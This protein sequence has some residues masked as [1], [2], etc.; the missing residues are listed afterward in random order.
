MRELSQKWPDI[1]NLDLAPAAGQHGLRDPSLP[2]ASVDKYRFRALPGLPE[3]AGLVR[4]V[5]LAKIPDEPVLAHARMP[6][7]QF[8]G[9]EKESPVPI[10]DPLVKTPFPEEPAGRAATRGAEAPGPG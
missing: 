2:A 1:E 5:D 6:R 9:Y 10:P 7:F 4:P 8:R 3:L